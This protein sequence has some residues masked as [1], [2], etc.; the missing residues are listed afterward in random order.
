[1]FS[2]ENKAKNIVEKADKPVSIQ[3][4]ANEL[5]ISWGTARA[6]L[7]SLALEGEIQG[8]RTDK[9]WIF[10]KGNLRWVS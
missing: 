2:Q 4:I 3:K 8:A 5:D 7:L 1:M 9:G 10:Y 6:M